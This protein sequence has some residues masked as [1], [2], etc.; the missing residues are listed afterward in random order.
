[1]VYNKTIENIVN[2]CIMEKKT[3]LDPNNN[4]K[5]ESSNKIL[6]MLGAK[7]TILS[8]DSQE[9]FSLEVKEQ[10]KKLYPLI[11]KLFLREPSLVK[12][13]NAYV[14]NCNDLKKL[15][16]IE[17]SLNSNLIDF[18]HGDQNINQPIQIAFTNFLKLCSIKSYSEVFKNGLDPE[19]IK[20]ATDFYSNH[21]LNIDYLH[22]SSETPQNLAFLAFSES[23]PVEIRNLL[24]NLKI[25]CNRTEHQFHGNTPLLTMVS[26]AENT[27]AMQL[28]ESSKK[29]NSNTLNL[30]ITSTKFGTSALHLTVAK[31]YKNIDFN[32]QSLDISNLKLAKALI[33]AGCNVNLK[34]DLPKSPLDGNTALHLACIRKDMDF[35]KLL[36]DSGADLTIKNAKGQTPLDL[37][38]LEKKDAAT[39]INTATGK[40]NNFNKI[41]SESVPPQ[42]FKDELTEYME[43]LGKSEHTKFTM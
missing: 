8:T 31:G 13:L 36:L 15:A 16:I 25:D 10:Q 35:C 43:S 42:Q 40:M 21:D 17:N 27:G 22:G 11:E 1:M 39:L 9:T 12:Q 29:N 18:K 24:F 14:Q 19:L 33:D 38:F 41:Y 5:N 23:I 7:K 6:E 26:N 30:D 4:N 37:L 34:V 20:I 3:S 2:G 28:I 32:N